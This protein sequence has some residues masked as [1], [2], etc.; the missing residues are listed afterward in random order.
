LR[1]R[2]LHES[3]RQLRIRGGQTTFFPP[4]HNPPSGDFWKPRRRIINQVIYDRFYKNGSR[5][6]RHERKEITE[7]QHEIRRP[8]ID[9]F[10]FS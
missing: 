2:V 1:E 3:G 4:L 7:P 10:S 6:I 8:G 5:L 9:V